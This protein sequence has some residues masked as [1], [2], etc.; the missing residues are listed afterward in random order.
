MRRLS[1]ELVGQVRARDVAARETAEELAGVAAA[2]AGR[3]AAAAEDVRG[4][5]AEFVLMR[6]LELVEVLR[7]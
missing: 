7:G 6:G 5:E 3:I 4:A 1:D 2:L